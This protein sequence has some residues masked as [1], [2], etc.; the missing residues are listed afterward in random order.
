MFMQASYIK[1]FMH[2]TTFYAHS[3]YTYQKLALTAAESEGKICYVT[4]IQLP[5]FAI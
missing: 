5:P 1:S 4:M 2:C 3:L